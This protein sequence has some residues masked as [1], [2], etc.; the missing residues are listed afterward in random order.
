MPEET[1]TNEATSNDAVEN[2]TTAPSLVPANGMVD[3][4]PQTVE[5]TGDGGKQP[6][7]AS[8]KRGRAKGSTAE[9]TA[10]KS[11]AAP[12]A[13]KTGSQSR[14]ARP[15]PAGTFEDSL[16]FASA[17][18]EYGSGTK[19]RRVSF[20]DHLGK[21]PE[22]GPSRQLVTNASKYGLISGNYASEQ[23]ELT[24]AGTKCVSPDTD[25]KEQKR[26]QIKLALQD[27]EPFNW[28]YEEYKGKALP[29]QQV[30]RDFL[31]SRAIAKEW[32]N[33][34]VDTY[35]GN[36]K[37]LGLLKVLSGAERVITVEHLI[38]EM[39]SRGTSVEATVRQS[40]GR[41]A[42]SVADTATDFSTTCFFVSPIGNEDSDERK[43]SDLFLN[44]IV[45]P[46]LA[47]FGL[48][49]VRADQIG[50]G[51]M[52]T[53]QIIEHLVRSKL[54]IAD[55]SFHNPNVFYELAI[56]HACRLPTVQIIQEG[57]KIPFD[58]DQVRTVIVD[59]SSIYSLVPQL[60]TYK[61]Q[62]ANQVRKALEEGESAEN[63]ISTFFPG[64]KVTIPS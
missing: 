50:H 16:E 60:E 7:K 25:A 28:L 45:A 37:F 27:I 29:A 18:F 42:V 11:G 6:N 38:E 13:G 54:V 1:R 61:S 23:L 19:V 24:P 34:C 2:P 30:M 3:G 62:I 36:L 33:E 52:I 10:S 20:F 31:E 9:E 63:P 39:P 64:L 48:N 22:S 8:P 41:A 40:T 26:S 49:I 4:E 32:L 35:I 57:D 12:Q 47:E 53:R 15:F 21:K 51:G 17:M 58:L 46:A 59:N 43:H 5:T 44:F 55:L 14:K 56:R